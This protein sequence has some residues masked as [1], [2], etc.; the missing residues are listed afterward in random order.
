MPH[1]TLE[2]EEDIR[3]FKISVHDPFL[4]HVTDGLG[5]LQADSGEACCGWRSCNSLRNYLWRLILYATFVT[6]EVIR[7]VVAPPH[8]D[9]ARDKP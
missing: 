2:R 7:T 6:K 9:P 5:D 3:R 4:V 1:L 8:G